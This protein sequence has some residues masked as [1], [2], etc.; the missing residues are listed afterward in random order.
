MWCIHHQRLTLPGNKSKIKLLQYGLVV[1]SIL[2]LFKVVEEEVRAG[3]MN[4]FK[5][6]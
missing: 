4:Y 1:L 6:G 5:E 2:E 3:M